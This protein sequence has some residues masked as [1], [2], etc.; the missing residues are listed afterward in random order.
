[1]KTLDNWDANANNSTRSSYKY[2][3]DSRGS[4]DKIGGSS[5]EEALFWD[6]YGGF[7]LPAA[8]PYQ[9]HDSDGGNVVFKNGR[10]IWLKR[11]DWFTG[12][13]PLDD[14]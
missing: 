4:G 1:M 14:N 12:N 10:V 11:Q 7:K 6:F 9:N 3:N 5:S 2:A 13:L 8:E